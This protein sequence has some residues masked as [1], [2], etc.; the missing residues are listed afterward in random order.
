[1]PEEFYFRK[2]K[3]LINNEITNLYKSS[4]KCVECDQYFDNFTKNCKFCKS[5]LVYK[6]EN[7]EFNMF[8]DNLEKSFSKTNFEQ[9]KKFIEM[10]IEHSSFK[11]FD[12]RPFFNEEIENCNEKN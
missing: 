6:P 8:I 3:G 4:P 10:H 9:V 5:A 12:L 1:V 2:V 11:I 7:E